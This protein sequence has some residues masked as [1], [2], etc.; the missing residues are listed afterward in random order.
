MVEQTMPSGAWWDE[1][2]QQWQVKA[3]ASLAELVASADNSDA[4]VVD[5][6]DSLTPAE[7]ATLTD[8]LTRHGTPLL[9]IVGMLNINLDIVTESFTHPVRLGHLLGRIAFHLRAARQNA[10]SEIT[11]AYAVFSPRDGTLTARDGIIKLTDMEARLLEY[12]CSRHAPAS[13]DDLL[14]EVWGYDGQI[15]T[16]TIETYIYRLR[17]KLAALSED[18]PVVLSEQGYAISHKWLI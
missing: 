8:Y 5:A 17:R 2:D 16:H 12:L 1:H 14:S 10:R 11:L 4:V 13:R 18:D 6:A 15:D 9:F 3:Y 7:S